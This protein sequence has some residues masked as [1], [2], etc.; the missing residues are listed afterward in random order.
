MNEVLPNGGSWQ[1]PQVAPTVNPLNKYF[2]VPGLHIKLPTNG[3]FMPPDSIEFSITNEVP[4]YPMRAADELLLKSPDALMSGYAIE[5]LIESCVPAITKPRLISSPDL[6]VLLLAVRA[7]TYGQV[8]HL[9]PICPQCG[10]TNE[11]HR[12][13]SFLIANMTFIEPEN[14]VRLNDEVIVFVRPY[15]MEA[16]TQLGVV[17]FEETRQLQAS[18]SLPMEQRSAQINKSMQRIADLTTK[19]MA[20]CILKVVVPSG[21]VVDPKMIHEFLLNVSKEWTD[22]IQKKIDEMNQKGI[23]KEYDVK[24][25]KCEHA[26]KTRIEFDP[27]TF[28]ES[29]SSL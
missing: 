7:A 25:A 1:M 23:E 12:N 16:A 6:D 11:A 18:E 5:K 9:A 17:S 22:R 2:R 28:F 27:S 20:E 10:A 26:W 15:N 3:A 4:V 21:E 14:P 24:C 13:L 8:I 29:S 19:L